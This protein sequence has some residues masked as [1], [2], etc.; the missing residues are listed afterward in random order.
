VQQKQRH[1]ILRCASV[2]ETRKHRKNAKRCCHEQGLS[3]Q[4]LERA[5]FSRKHLDEFTEL[6]ALAGSCMHVI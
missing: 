5:A 2:S 3:E 1:A 6:G 4:A